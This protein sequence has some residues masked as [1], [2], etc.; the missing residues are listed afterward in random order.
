[1]AFLKKKNKQKKKTTELFISHLPSM[2]WSSFP[3]YFQFF[4]CSS[5]VSSCLRAHVL[6]LAWM[7]PN[8]ECFRNLLVFSIETDCDLCKGKQLLFVRKSFVIKFEPLVKWLASSLSC[9]RR[10]RVCSSLKVLLPPVPCRW[11]PSLVA[12]TPYGMLFKVSHQPT[13]SLRSKRPKVWMPSMSAC[14]RGETMLLCLYPFPHPVRRPL[15][16]LKAEA[17]R[18]FLAWASITILA[19]VIMLIATRKVTRVVDMATPE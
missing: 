1:M 2:A 8:C 15:L 12:K 10:A 4:G 3:N 6:I 16:P 11:E 5:L 17:L 9:G 13:R 14:R 18:T 19:A 7:L